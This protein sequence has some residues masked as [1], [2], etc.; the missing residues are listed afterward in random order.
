MFELT[1]C[2]EPNFTDAKR[3]KTLKYA[4]LLEDIEHSGYCGALHTIEV[5]SRGALN[6]EGLD[7]LQK[8]L[9]IHKQ[10]WTSFLVSVS[11]KAMEESHRIWVERNW[12]DEPRV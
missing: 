10:R 12:R 9:G 7:C 3:R 5:G 8:F 1:V 2:F 4:E 11:Q 6:M